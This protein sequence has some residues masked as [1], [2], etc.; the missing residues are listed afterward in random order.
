MFLKHHHLEVL[1]RYVRN[2]EK[3]AILIQAIVRGYLQKCKYE[4]LLMRKE[5]EERRVGAL[6]REIGQHSDEI[7]ECLE[8]LERVDEERLRSGCG[9]LL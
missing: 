9:L 4:K 8:R 1:N 5:E 6:L 7:V 2:K 3:S